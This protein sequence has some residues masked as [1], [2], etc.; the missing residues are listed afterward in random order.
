MAVKLG[1][2]HEVLTASRFGVY[3]EDPSSMSYIITIKATRGEHTA[4]VIREHTQHALFVIENNR[5]FA[6]GE[7]KVDVGRI[8]PPNVL[9]QDN[10]FVRVLLQSTFVTPAAP[11]ENTYV[12]TWKATS[13][14]LLTASPINNK[15]LSTR[16]L[17]T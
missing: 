4:G 10:Q 14:T 7:E 2:T 9:G 11:N 5:Q 13:Q 15:F 3:I 12:Y 17:V 1:V 8:R 16:R 6:V